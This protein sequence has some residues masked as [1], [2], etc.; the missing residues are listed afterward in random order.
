MSARGLRMSRSMKP[1][2][3]TASKLTF[4]D[5]KPA[6]CAPPFQAAFR[7][8]G[9]VCHLGVQRMRAARMQAALWLQRSRKTLAGGEAVNERES[10]AHGQTLLKSALS[11]GQYMTGAG[12][13][14]SV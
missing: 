5:A 14:V 13:R 3:S 12:G 7:G 8:L 4:D 9:R 10:A 6:P 11:S 1:L 2:A